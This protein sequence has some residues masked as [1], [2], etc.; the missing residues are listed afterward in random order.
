MSSN[1]DLEMVGE[2]LLTSL[3]DEMLLEICFEMH[4]NVSLSRGRH[5][6]QDYGRHATFM[7]HSLLS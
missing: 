3:V 1:D 7:T 4:Y 5:R 6:Q 2:Q